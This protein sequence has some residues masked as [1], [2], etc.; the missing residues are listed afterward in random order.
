VGYVFTSILAGATEIA[1]ERAFCAAKSGE[2]CRFATTGIASI[3]AG[4]NVTAS[5]LNW[6]SA[7]IT[8]AADT[9]LSIAMIGESS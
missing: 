5:I 2:T 7:T 9:A 4:V 8:V 3:A 6:H 1:R